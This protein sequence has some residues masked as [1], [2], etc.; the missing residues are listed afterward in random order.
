MLKAAAKVIQIVISHPDVKRYCSDHSFEWHFNLEKAPWWGGMFERMIKST[1]RC[2]WKMV[3]Q[4][5]FTHE[6]LL[7]AVI[8]IEAIINARPLSYTPTEDIEEHPHTLLCGRRLLSS[9]EHL[10]YCHPLN[11]EDFKIS[12]AQAARRAKHLNNMLN[13]FWR[14]WRQEYLLELRECHQYS[15]GKDS[16]PTVE[17]GDIVLLYDDALPRNF[18]K[19]ARVLN[20]IA[21]RDG[22]TRGAVVRVPAKSGETTTLRC[23]LQRLYPLEVKC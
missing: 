12:P 3:G 9:P 22:K 11:D 5:H 1:K 16:T 14:C 23:P 13:H 20:L 15:R 2:R 17:V 7:T 8:E 10:T 6:E 21:G 19:L 18:W 4:A